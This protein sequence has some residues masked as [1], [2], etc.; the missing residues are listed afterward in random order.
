MAS[1]N[2]GKKLDRR[3]KAVRLTA[4]QNKEILE[5]LARREH[6]KDIAAKFNTNEKAISRVRDQALS[7][8]SKMRASLTNEVQ[9]Y[10]T[11][12]EEMHSKKMAG[13]PP[14][15]RIQNIDDHFDDL[16]K[17]AKELADLLVEFKDAARD[18]TIDEI[19]EG[20]FEAGENFDM[21]EFFYKKITRGLFTHLKQSELV[22]G[23]DTLNG[24]GD[25][26]VSKVDDTFIRMMRLEAA[27]RGF[28]GTC[29]LCRVKPGSNRKVA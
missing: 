28:E 8:T 22:L 12:W 29:D 3:E 17:C 4:V 1:L 9:E 5:L 26:E 16:A 21:I 14:K 15:N 19:I 18:D 20:S 23:L 2:S 27:I 24:W 10:L 13:S 7:Y 6:R 11:L 25:L